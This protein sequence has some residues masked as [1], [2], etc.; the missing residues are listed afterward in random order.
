MKVNWVDEF[1]FVERIIL[2]LVKSVVSWT[3]SNDKDM[4][5]YL[6]YNPLSKPL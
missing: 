2:E 6:P 5:I 4:R 3:G 1:Y